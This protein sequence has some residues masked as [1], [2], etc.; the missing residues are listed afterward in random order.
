[1]DI[2]MKKLVALAAAALLAAGLAVP[3]LAESQSAAAYEVV[4]GENFCTG[5]FDA[6]PLGA[7]PQKGDNK[8]LSATKGWRSNEY[9]HATVS[10]VEGG[11]K[12]GR[13][14]Q[15]QGNGTNPYGAAYFLFPTG[16][17][18]RRETYEVSFLYKATIPC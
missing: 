18:K 13:C 2:P 4:R 11:Y 8:D 9:D 14:L 5:T 15:I 17:I 12:G 3:A 7:L 1:M 16:S 6:V 10:I